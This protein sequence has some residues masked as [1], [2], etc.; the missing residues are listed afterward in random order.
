MHVKDENLGI[1]FELLEG[2]KKVAQFDSHIKKYGP[3]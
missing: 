1:Y 3:L 2:M